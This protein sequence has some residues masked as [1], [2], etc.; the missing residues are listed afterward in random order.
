MPKSV[1]HPL[2]DY[3]RTLMH[4]FFGKAKTLEA[5]LGK[6]NFTSSN[7]RGIFH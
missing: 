2:F 1:H 4:T 3:S 7:F 5:Q 6:L